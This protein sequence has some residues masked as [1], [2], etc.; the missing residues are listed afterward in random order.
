MFAEY[1]EAALERAA[2]KTLEEEPM[3]ERMII[4]RAYPE[5]Q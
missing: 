5:M 3:H 4:R 2:Y 1:I